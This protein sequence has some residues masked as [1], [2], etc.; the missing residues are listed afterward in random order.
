[1]LSIFSAL[2]FEK[3]KN[4]NVYMFVLARK[5][6]KVSYYS[7]IILMKLSRVDNVKNSK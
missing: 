3:K 5:G 4:E 6:L 1:M 7:C 2:P